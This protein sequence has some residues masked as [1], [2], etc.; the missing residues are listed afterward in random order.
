MK[1]LFVTL[2][3]FGDISNLKTEVSLALLKGLKKITP[4]VDIICRDYKNFSGAKRALPFGRLLSYAFQGYEKFINKSRL[5]LNAFSR[6]RRLPF[7]AV[8]LF[9]I[10]KTTSTLSV[11]LTSFFSDSSLVPTKS[12]FS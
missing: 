2:A 9:I 6:V 1:I 10:E 3:D 8:V 4:N 12:S 7:E 11:G 5:L